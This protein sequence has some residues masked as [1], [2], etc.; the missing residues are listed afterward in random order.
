MDFSKY[1]KVLYIK[2]YG[3]ISIVNDIIL[4][5][6]DSYEFNIEITSNSEYVVKE[7]S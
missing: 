4:D 1:R 3:N 7:I 2:T 6:T 5:I